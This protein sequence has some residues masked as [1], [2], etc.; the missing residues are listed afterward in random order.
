MTPA[1]RDGDTV[2]IAPVSGTAIRVGDVICYGTS[3]A[4]ILHRVLRCAR[5]GFVAKGDAQTSFDLVPMPDVLGRV[6]ARARGG[7]RRSFVTRRARLVNR[8]TALMSPAI[9][10]LLPVALWMR[11]LARRATA[12]S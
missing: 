3:R 9:P 4:L 11:Q 1:L 10:R 12:R 2:E 7:R 8:L 5:D 6:V